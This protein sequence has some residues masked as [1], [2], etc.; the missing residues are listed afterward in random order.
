MLY[1][2]AGDWASTSSST[3]LFDIC[4]GTGTIGITLA[5]HVSKVIGIDN[6]RESVDDARANAALNGIT[7]CEYVCS[8]AEDALGGLLDK[9][10]HQYQEVIAIVDP[11]R[12]GLH[13]DVC[14]AILR[15]AAV[16]RLVYI[17]C[18]PDS[19]STNMAQLCSP[20]GA[21]DSKRNAGRWGRQAGAQQQQQGDAAAADADSSYAPFVPNKAVAVDLFPH[22]GHVETVV[23]LKR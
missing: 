17:S 8:K 2:V 14:K 16:R 4:C 15:C 18:N 23:L 22:T 5:R 13:K 19:L 12:A 21:M 7:N 20:P 11:P 6:V 9:H 1:K 10:A 3:L